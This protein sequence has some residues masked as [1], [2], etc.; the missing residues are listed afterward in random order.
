MSVKQTPDA[1]WRLERIASEL[2]NCDLT[3]GFCSP[4]NVPGCK[5]WRYAKMAVHGL[6]NT[7][8]PALAEAWPDIPEDKRR[9][10]LNR[11]CDAIL[12]REDD[13]TAELI[14][15]AAE[16]QKTGKADA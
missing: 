10:M 1:N 8:N 3:D 14:A 5:C 9:P 2:C 7:A 6:R 15:R 12:N 16:N 11:L 13:L 4:R